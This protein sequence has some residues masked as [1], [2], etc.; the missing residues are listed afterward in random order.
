MGANLYWYLVPYEENFNE[1]LE[2]LRMREFKAGR[3]NP[4]IPFPKFP[5]TDDSESPGPQHSDINQ[6]LNE[7]EYDGTRSIL[8]LITVSE[9]D[10]YCVARILSKE[11]LLNYFGTE[12]PDAETIQVKTGFIEDIERGK[13]RCIVVYEND[14]AK[15]LFF[16]GYSFD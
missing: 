7:T 10:D 2:K 4:V 14:Q 13:G 3:Y 12:K 16:I 1:V 11:E 8:D 9:E 6:P 5:I 15:D